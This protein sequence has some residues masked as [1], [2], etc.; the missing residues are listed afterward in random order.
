MWIDVG[1]YLIEPRHIAALGP[2]RPFSSDNAVAATFDIVTTGGHVVLPRFPDAPAA[3]AA[4][5]NLRGMLPG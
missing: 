5:N 3:T 4:R 1:G 2:V